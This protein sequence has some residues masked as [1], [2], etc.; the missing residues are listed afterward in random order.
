MKNVKYKVSVA[1]AALLAAAGLQSCDLDEYNPSGSTADVVF[2]TPE[3]IESLVNAM[4]F[5]FRWKYFGREDPV[6]YI[7]G[8]T[9]L[10]LNQSNQ[11][12]GQKMTR[13]EGLQGDVGQ[14][15]NVWNRVYD[16]INLANAVINRIGGVTYSNPV[17]KAVHEGEARWRPPHPI[18]TPT[19]PPLRRFT[20]R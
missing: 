2:S 14:I 1:L 6:L 19:A 16:D 11:N 12:Y 10:W 5:N 13:Y 8:S 9:D 4:Y 15:A 7:E 18:S 17:D 20:T 3:G